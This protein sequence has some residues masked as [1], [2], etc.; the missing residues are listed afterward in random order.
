MTR[1]AVEHDTRSACM[2]L[3]PDASG[4]GHRAAALE[5]AAWG[6]S[7]VAATAT[8]DVPTPR[9]CDER[10]A[11]VACVPGQKVRTRSGPTSVILMPALRAQVEMCPR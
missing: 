8:E 2:T 3:M 11:M 7:M 4:E 9:R 6:T 5:S 10:I 1:L